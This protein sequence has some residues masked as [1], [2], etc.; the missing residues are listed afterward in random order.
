MPLHRFTAQTSGKSN[1]R[2][3]C[4]QNALQN[5]CRCP[6]LPADKNQH[7]LEEATLKFKEIQNAYEILSDKHER[8]WYDS[9]H[10]QQ[11]YQ[12]I[13]MPALFPIPSQRRYMELQ[14]V[15]YVF[16]KQNGPMPAGHCR[17][18][19]HTCTNIAACGSVPVSWRP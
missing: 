10:R 6:L 18:R 17:R 16:P 12:P 4:H 14:I 19:P 7:R 5:E 9:T 2:D 13:A 15:T 8:A 11:V 1:A 3:D